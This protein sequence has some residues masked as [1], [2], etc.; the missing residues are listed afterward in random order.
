MV[1]GMSRIIVWKV[2]KEILIWLLSRL[3]FLNKGLFNWLLFEQLNV[4]HEC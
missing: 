2:E 4:G 3:L 1:E